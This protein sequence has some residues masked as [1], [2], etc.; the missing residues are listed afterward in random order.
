MIKGNYDEAF[1]REKWSPSKKM[2]KRRN[3]S[4]SSSDSPAPDLIENYSN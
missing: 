3:S 2:I 1:G 4:G